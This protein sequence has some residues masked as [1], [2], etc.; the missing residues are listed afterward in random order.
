M[1]ADKDHIYMCLAYWFFKKF[2]L[3]VSRQ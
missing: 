3:E 2:Q 1:Y